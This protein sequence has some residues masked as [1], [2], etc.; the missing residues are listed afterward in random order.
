MSSKQRIYWMGMGLLAGYFI[1]KIVLYME[2]L[3]FENLVKTNIE[4]INN[5]C[6][7]HFC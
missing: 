2:K 4:F 7:F 1:S 6:N 5:P 3:Y